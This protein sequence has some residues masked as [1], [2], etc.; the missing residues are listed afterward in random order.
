[1]ENKICI[2]Y[3][4]D[5][6]R[7]Y[8]FEKFL[9]FLNKINNKDKIYLLIL[10]NNYDE[11]FFHNIIIN[12][13]NNIKYSIVK[14]S[15]DN[16]YINKIKYFIDYTKKINYKYCLKFDNDLIINNYTIDYLIENIKIIDNSNN[17]FITPSISSGIPTVDIFINDFFSEDE[18]NIIN[19][20]FKKTIM[21]NNIW[22]FDYS[23]LNEN[24]INSEKWDMKE[25]WKNVDSLPYYYKGLHPIRINPDAI[26][27]LNKIILKYKNKIFDKQDYKVKITDEYPYFCNS[28]FAIK[29]NDYDNIVSNNSLY[30]DPFDEV[31]V[32]KYCKLNKMNGVF[33][34]NTFSIH[35][36][37][38]TIPNHLNLEKFFFY[39][40]FKNN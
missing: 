1:M 3:L 40:F 7:V 4:T 35:P 16:N 23:K 15:N 10:L 20:L 22:G 33:I 5:D 28:I 32:N 19:N 37:Y 11:N 29:V 26:L 36:F 17:L 24:T 14:F 18:I 12:N 21:P 38:N 9:Y 27:Y 39:E 8:T 13:S 2:G 6:R 30:V 34:T 25:Y 31:P